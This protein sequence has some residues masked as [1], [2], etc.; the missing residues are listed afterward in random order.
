MIRWCPQSYSFNSNL[1]ISLR[2]RLQIGTSGSLRE[3]TACALPQRSSPLNPKGS[4]HCFRAQGPA[5]HLENHPP[6]LQTGLLDLD[7]S[8][9]SATVAAA[10][11]GCSLRASHKR[12]V[13]AREGLKQVLQDL[14]H[15]D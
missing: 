8:S 4:G 9:D 14:Y 2:I 6:H 13:C 1:G 12:W 11:G 5:V 7:T 15:E 10:R 3:Q